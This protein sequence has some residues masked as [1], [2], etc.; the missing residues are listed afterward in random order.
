MATL[1]A[2]W[3]LHLTLIVLYFNKISMHFITAWFLQS[4]LKFN[5]TKC[6]H[7]SLKPYLVISYYILDTLVT[8]THIQKDLGILISSDLSWDKHYE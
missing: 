7:I 4:H 3:V 6:S 5:P 1:S 8:S 2:S